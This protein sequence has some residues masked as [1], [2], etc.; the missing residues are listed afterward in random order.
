MS[1]L[2]LS[3]RVALWTYLILAP[4]SLKEWICSRFL[5]KVALSWGFLKFRNW[6]NFWETMIRDTSKSYC[7]RRGK[8]LSKVTKM[9][10]RARLQNCMEGS[11]SILSKGQRERTKAKVYH[12]VAKLLKVR[13]KVRQPKK[14]KLKRK[15]RQFRHRIRKDYQLINFLW[16]SKTQSMKLI[17]K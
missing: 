12:L 8:R 11:K 16:K 1:F 9:L 10:K 14:E 2:E 15:A 3:R 4:R 17:S 5:F 7:K 6:G 13:W